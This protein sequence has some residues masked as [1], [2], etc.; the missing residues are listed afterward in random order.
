[1]AGKATRVRE[2]RAKRV[3]TFLGVSKYDWVS[4][5]VSKVAF[6]YGMLDNICVLRS[7]ITLQPLEMRTGSSVT[8]VS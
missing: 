4:E 7:Q 2:F 5:D 8:R 6:I 3:G 1:M